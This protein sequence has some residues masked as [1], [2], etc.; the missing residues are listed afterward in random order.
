MDSKGKYQG[1]NYHDLGIDLVKQLPEAINKPLNI[2]QSD[3]KSDSV[4]IV[5]ELADKQDRPV[6]ASIKIDGTGRIND[7][8]FDSNVMTSA[9]G[10]NNY[11]EF[12]KRNIKKGN[13]L[14]DIDEGIIKR[15]S[16][17]LQLRPTDSSYKRVNGQWLDLPNS[18]NSS[19][20]AKDRV[21]FPIRNNLSDNNTTTNSQKKQ[22]A[23]VSQYNMQ[24]SEKNIPIAKEYQ[25]NTIDEKI[26]NNEDILKIKDIPK[27]PTK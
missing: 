27:D 14:Y 23:P 8:E 21:Q 2:L 22:I 18:N 10:R 4:V 5:T 20:V 17:K 25:K 12:M 13:L 3:T 1:A 15:I 7:I 26:E 11:D 19:K 9:Y 6:I 16:G 24:Q